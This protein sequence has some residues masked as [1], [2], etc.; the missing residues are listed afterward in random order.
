MNLSISA[1]PDLLVAKI[2]RVTW[3]RLLTSVVDTD[4]LKPDTDPDLAFQVISDPD[5]DSGVWWPKFFSFLILIK[6]CNLLSPRPPERTSKIQKK[7]SKRTSSLSKHEISLLFLLLWVIFVLLD[8]DSESGSGS[9][10][11]IVSGS[12]S[13]TLILTCGTM[14]RC[15]RPVGGGQRQRDGGLPAHQ[16]PRQEYSQEC[17]RHTVPRTPT[18]P[19]QV[20]LPCGVDPDPRIHASD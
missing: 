9:T 17:A 2:I 7:L 12:G 18:L 10:D 15:D 11:L 5:T 3:Y 1:Y 6:T 13:E 19:R 8:P 20:A 16:P 14:S 4:S